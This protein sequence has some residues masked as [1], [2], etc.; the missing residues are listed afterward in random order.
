VKSKQ[1]RGSSLSALIY[2]ARIES[3]LTIK[4]HLFLKLFSDLELSGKNLK[5]KNL[6]KIVTLFLLNKRKMLKSSSQKR[7]KKP[8]KPRKIRSFKTKLI[9]SQKRKK[10]KN[11]RILEKN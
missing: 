3:S 6:K 9:L 5:N 10:K 7:L 4:R 11:P 1:G 2:L 8:S